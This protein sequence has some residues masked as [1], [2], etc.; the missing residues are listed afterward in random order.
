MGEHDE[1]LDGI[2]D[3]PALDRQKAAAS[4]LYEERVVRKLMTRLG[5]ADRI[6]SMAGEVRGLTGTARLT[7][8]YFY[9]QHPDFPVWLV[10]KR[11]P[12]FHATPFRE[13][14]S[15]PKSQPFLKQWLEANDTAPDGKPVAL[16]FACPGVK[17]SHLVL[18][19]W[20][21]AVSHAEGEDV[22]VFLSANTPAG[23]ELLCL[24][25]FDHFAADLDNSFLR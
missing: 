4:A 18:H 14:F 10:A 16:V 15:K 5:M 8:A 17:G 9:S 6:K 23:R 3:D 13:I 21:P 11:V 7:F 25:R 24:E 22:R 12:Y 2:Y 20:L 19:N 1:L